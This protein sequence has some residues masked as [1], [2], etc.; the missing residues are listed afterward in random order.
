MQCKQRGFESPSQHKKRHKTPKMHQSAP[1]RTFDAIT[2]DADVLNIALSIL[3]PPGAGL[4]LT[5]LETQIHARGKK[6][7]RNNK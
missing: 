6:K 5:A 4:R 1:M 2:A 7:N 3:R